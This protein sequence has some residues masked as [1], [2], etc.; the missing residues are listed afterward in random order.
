MHDSNQW[1]Y[2]LEIKVILFNEFLEN[3]VQNLQVFTIAQL[4]G[5]KLKNMWTAYF[6][7]HGQPQNEVYNISCSTNCTIINL[8]I[9]FIQRL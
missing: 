4:R 5:E 6:I 9:I 1:Q 2:I 3:L 7:H 8:Q